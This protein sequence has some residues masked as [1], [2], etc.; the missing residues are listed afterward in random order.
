M[1]LDAEQDGG[2]DD[3]VVDD[4]GGGY[5]EGGDDDIGLEVQTPTKPARTKS[6]SKAQTK[7]TGKA[8]PSKERSLGAMFKSA[9]M[10]TLGTAKP[11][12]QTD[13]D[14]FMTSLMDELEIPTTPSKSAKRRQSVAPPDQASSSARR[15]AAATRGTP[16][17]SA[18]PRA[19]RPIGVMDISDPKLDPFG[20]PPAKKARS[21]LEDPFQDAPLSPE[22]KPKEEPGTV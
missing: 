18:T 21:D 2:M 4:D 19:S 15:R 5:V 17:H 8:Q 7:S 6:M 13:D 20:P 14:A 3:F 11:R 22:R 12:R 10:K 9:H 16:V 1:S